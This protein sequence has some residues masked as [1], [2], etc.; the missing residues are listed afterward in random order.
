[1]T[2]EALWLL[3]G[4]LL[5][6]YLGDFTPLA[7][8]RMQEAKANAGPL[9]TIGAH[10]GIHGLLVGLAVALLAAPVWT[11]IIA[12]AAIEFVTHF[13]LDTV[14]ARLGR[15][16][17]KLNDPGQRAFWYALGADQLGHGLVLLGLAFLVL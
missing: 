11:L 9:P 2:A 3:A 17:P 8:A 13:G 6:H 12:A 4:L 1:M 5:A 14:R 16:F 15:R 7:S 10:A